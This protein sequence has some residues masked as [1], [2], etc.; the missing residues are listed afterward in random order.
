MLVLRY[1]LDETEYCTRI[2]F[3]FWLGIT[4]NN[5]LSLTTTTFEI[6]SFARIFKNP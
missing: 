1:S 5:D 2:C 4:R 3:K 6:N